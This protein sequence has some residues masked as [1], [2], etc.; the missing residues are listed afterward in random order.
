MKNVES[1]GGGEMPVEEKAEILSE[2]MHKMQP[3]FEDFRGVKGFSDYDLRR[4]QRKLED[5]NWRDGGR[6][7]SESAEDRYAKEAEPIVTFVLN[8]G[9]F[10]PS[11][12]TYSYLAS[13]FDDKI[14]GTDVVFGVE[15]KDHRG[16][17]VFSVDV[18]TGTNADSI[19]EKFRVSEKNYWVANLDYCMHENKRW[20]EREAPHFILGMMPASLDR[21]MDKVRIGE[22]T[23]VREPD[24]TTDFILASEM[25]EQIKMQIADVESGYHDDMTDRQLAKLRE[26]KPAVQMKLYKVCNVRGDTKEARAEDF[27]VKYAKIMKQMRGDL[28]YRNI[29]DEVRR[30][31]DR[32]NGRKANGALR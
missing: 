4:D 30:I 2:L 12:E 13:E 15:R 24:A 17:T 18:A 8:H 31:N 16:D 23:M 21:A 6:F 10:L 22:G 32:N 11:R 1:L 25:Y 19:R 9:S 5:K 28:V 7:K 20:S 26:L 3:D 29:I 27:A 14:N